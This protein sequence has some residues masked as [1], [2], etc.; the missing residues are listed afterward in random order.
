MK[1]VINHEVIVTIVKRGYG[2]YVISAA[3]E[4]GATGATIISGRGTSPSKEKQILGISIQP[5]KDVVIILV[6][7]SMRKS[8]MQAI[9]KATNLNNESTG[10]SFSLPVTN[11]AG[12]T[13]IVTKINKGET[14]KEYVKPKSRLKK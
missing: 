12:L 6:D 7:K 5:E 11:A 10:V 3:R 8:V 4:Q 9:V 14:T 2:D 1:T 13:Q